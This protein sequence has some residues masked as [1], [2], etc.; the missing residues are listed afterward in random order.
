MITAYLTKP[1]IMDV[2]CGGIDRCTVWL[3]TPP[4]YR[5]LRLV[6]PVFGEIIDPN[7]LQPSQ[8]RGEQQF[9]G[10]ILRKAGGQLLDYA[11]HQILSTYNVRHFDEMLM[12]V[13]KASD[14]FHALHNHPRPPTPTDIHASYLLEEERQRYIHH[15]LEKERMRHHE[16]AL[17]LTLDIGFSADDSYPITLPISPNNR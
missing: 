10:K 6:C 8:W 4:E 15:K 3:R 5:P 11:W 14:E 7:E 13:D 16:W 12:A 9:H 17:K 1:K 2:I